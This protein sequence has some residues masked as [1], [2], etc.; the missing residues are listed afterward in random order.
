MPRLGSSVSMFIHRLAPSPPLVPTHRP[1]MSRYP[2]M[3]MPI[4][5]YTG[6]LA[7]APSRTFSTSASV[8]R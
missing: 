8:N 4:A 1:K 6:R 3:V 5:T 7:T 2:S